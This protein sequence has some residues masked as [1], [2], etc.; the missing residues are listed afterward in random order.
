ML[1]VQAEEQTRTAVQLA[2]LTVTSL[3]ATARAFAVQTRSSIIMW[4]RLKDSLRTSGRMPQ[5]IAVE[6]AATFEA[7]TS[8]NDISGVYK[9]PLF[10]PTD[11]CQRQTLVREFLCF[12][13]CSSGSQVM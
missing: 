7:Q 2:S 3:H 8:E 5:L 11:E 4:L 12:S 6:I 13:L 1:L 10:F 9:L